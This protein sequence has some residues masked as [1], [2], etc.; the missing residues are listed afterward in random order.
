MEGFAVRCSVSHGADV[1]RLLSAHIKFN[2]VKCP[3][4]GGPM[5]ACERCGCLVH[6][7]DRRGGGCTLCEVAGSF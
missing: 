5:V 3:L 4:C 1:A 7:K 6:A 2:L